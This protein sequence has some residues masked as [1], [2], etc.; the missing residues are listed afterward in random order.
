MPNPRPDLPSRPP[1]VHGLIA[2]VFIWSDFHDRFMISDVIGI[3]ASAGF[4]VTNRP[5]DFA[6]WSRLGRRDKDDVQ[7][8]FDPAAN[9]PKWRFMIG[10]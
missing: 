3:N 2:E 9:Q 5:N 1:K 4:D 8:R 6:T 10:P 7:R